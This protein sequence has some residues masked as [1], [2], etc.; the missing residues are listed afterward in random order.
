MNL[1][2][3]GVEYF[4]IS[5]LHLVAATIQVAPPRFLCRAHEV[6]EVQSL[7]HSFCTPCFCE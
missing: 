2:S 1:D 4:S 3:D 7:N 5:H 6:R